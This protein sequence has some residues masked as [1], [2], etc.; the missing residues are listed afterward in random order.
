MLRHSAH[1]NYF[2]DGYVPADADGSKPPTVYEYL[3]CF[4]HGHQFSGNCWYAERMG[5][6]QPGT[7]EYERLQRSYADTLEKLTWYKVR[8][9]RRFNFG[10]AY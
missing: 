10:F 3:G 9:R 8:R 5:L 2:P 7:P 4:W 6:K 1:G